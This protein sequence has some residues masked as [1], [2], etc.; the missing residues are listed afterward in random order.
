MK[1]AY[2]V[3]H[4]SKRR[5]YHPSNTSAG[6]VQ[7]VIDT[8]GAVEDA[9]RAILDKKKVRRRVY[10]ITQFEGEPTSEAIWLQKSQ[11]SNYR[12]L[13]AEFENV[14]RGRRTSEGR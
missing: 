5:P 12:E 10:Y 8:S 6:P 11:L 3:F 4:V 13:I 7:V 2:N 14:R 1:K 9:V